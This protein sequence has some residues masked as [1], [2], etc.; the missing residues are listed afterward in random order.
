MVLYW[1][2]SLTALLGSSLFI[3]AVVEVEGVCGKGGLQW[4]MAGIS[5]EQCGV[6]RS[7]DVISTGQAL[8]EWRSSEQVENGT[9]STS[10]PYWDSDDSDDTG[11]CYVFLPY[12]SSNVDAFL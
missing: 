10:P 8:A 9:P 7:T 11:K 6:G 5:S 12:T 4:N 1:L 3:F 2:K